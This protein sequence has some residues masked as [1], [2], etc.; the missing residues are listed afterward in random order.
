MRSTLRTAVV[1]SAA[2]GAAVLGAPATAS[3]EE[4]GPQLR[5]TVG[6][7]V[8]YDVSYPQ[9]DRT[10]PDDAAFAVIGVNGGIAT[11]ENRCLADQWE[12]ADDSSGAVPA[13][14]RAQLYV[15][16]ANPGE[17]R[18]Q[19]TT[20]PRLG[21]NR[22]GV[23]DGDNS[24]ACSYEYGVDRAE[25]D[26]RIVLDTLGDLDGDAAIEDRSDLVGLR[27]W[28]DV[29]TMNTWQTDGAAAQRNNRATLEGMTDHLES[30]GG[31]VG[32][33]STGYQWGEIVGDVPSWS[34]L[35]GLDSWLAG[36]RS[37]SGAVANCSDSPLVDGGRVIMTQYVEDD[38]DHNHS[39]VAAALS[40]PATTAPA[41]TTRITTAPATTAPS[42][43]A[44]ASATPTTAGASG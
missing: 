20:W 9:C 29:E 1:A 35:H 14:P 25:D 44:P 21:V 2:L 34:S 40:A 16:T 13:Q 7:T 43:T 39:C 15:N 6:S 11:T 27:W 37:L 26:V 23:C 24:A 10:L 18:E 38:L 33:Y 3:A 5:S 31:R 17:V 22:Y 30:V 8:G 32:L 42:T 19:V 4:P 36:A 41:T 12:W 28:L